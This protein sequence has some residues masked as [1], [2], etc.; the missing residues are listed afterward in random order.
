MSAFDQVHILTA[1]DGGESGSDSAP[2]VIAEAGCKTGDIVRKTMAAGVT[3]PL[4]ARPS[5]G[6]GLWLQGGIGHLARMHG[7]ACDSIVGAVL[8]SVDSSQL[9]YIGRVPSQHRPVG[10]VRPDNESD[11]LWAIKDAGTNFGIVVSV[12]LEAYTAPMFSTRNWVIQLSDNQEAWRKLSDF[13]DLVARKLPQN[14][15]A[16]VYLYWDIGQLHFG[17]TIF[18]SFTTR[19]SSETPMSTPTPIKTIL[20]PEDNFQVVD[21]VGLFDTEMYMSRMHG[22]HAKSETSSFKRCLFLTRIGALNVAKILVAAIETRPSPLSYLHLLQGGG[23]ISDVPADAT[24]FGCR[25]WDFTCVI[26][27]VW[28]REQDGT[29]VD[30]AAVQWVY[31]VASN[32]LPMSSGV[33]G[34]DLRPDPRDTALAAKAFGQNLPR[35][36]CLKQRSDPRNM[37]AYSC[38]LPKTPTEQKLIILVT[39]ASGAGKDHCANI[40]VSV[41]L[42]CTHK[43]L[44]ARA[45]SISDAT[46]REYAVATGADFNRLLRDRAYKEQHR[47]ALT[48]YIQSQV[49]H[50]PRLPEEH[51]LNVVDGAGDVDVLLITGMRDEAPVAAFSH[52]VP[53]SRLLDVR[54]KASKET[55]RSRRGYHGGD[56]DE[57]QHVLNISQQPGGF[58]LCTSLLH[59]RFTGDW[60]KVDI[61]VC[62][63]AGGFIYASA[64]ASQVDVPLALIREAGKLATPTHRFRTQEYIPHL[65]D[66]QF[67]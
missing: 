10:A 22:G 25:D 26:T 55:R 43:R 36:A 17:V 64:L 3:V 42:K 5:V 30:R 62:Y 28:P 12:T 59:T 29:E 35:L 8:V 24:T 27:G 2:L 18:E 15:S 48:T 47:P 11:L 31:N 37:L 57:F 6:A 23:A 49:Q 54:V 1:E 13:D 7:L 16:D 46:K 53:G 38:P 50:R 32:L 9:L 51:F 67:K 61:I 66:I 58:A 52:L 21:G 34:A 20:G 56:S 39:G 14:C 60:A 33:Y 63:E 4:G 41:F 40:W 45:V 44:M 65:L 19:V